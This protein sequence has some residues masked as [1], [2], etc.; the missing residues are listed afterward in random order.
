MHQCKIVYSYF[1]GV[2][3]HM[4]VHHSNGDTVSKNDGGGCEYFQ[5]CI[6]CWLGMDRFYSSWCVYVCVVSLSRVRFNL[7]FLLFEL[8]LSWKLCCIECGF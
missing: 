2:Y 6:V 3:V 8:P 4:F 7:N 1:S 5:S